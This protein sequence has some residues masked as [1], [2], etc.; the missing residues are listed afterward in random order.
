MKSRE[1]INKLTE[2][3][4]T[5]ESHVV[6]SN[7]DVTEIFT[8]PWY[9]DGRAKIFIKDSSGKIIGIR[10]ATQEDGPK[11]VIQ[12]KGVEDLA[13]DVVE[14]S[15]YGEPLEDFLVEGKDYFIQQYKTAKEEAIKFYEELNKKDED[16]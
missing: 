14:D 11:I 7:G 6:F 10:E 15:E 4:P 3:D 16:T 12:T 13:W 9:Y 8:L 2:L 5:G 1:L